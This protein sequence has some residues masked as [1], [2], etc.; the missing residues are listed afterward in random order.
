[1]L[2]LEITAIV[3]GCMGVCVK[4]VRRKLMSKAQ[5]HYQ[6]KTHGESKLNSLTDLISKALEDEQLSESEFKMVLC[7][8]EKYIDLKDKSHTNKSGLSEQEKKG[9]NGKGESG[10][11]QYHSI[12]KRHIIL[13]NK[14][15][16]VNDLPPKYKKT[17][18]LTHFGLTYFLY[19]FIRI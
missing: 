4:L 1:M 11:S 2:P 8:L 13:F 15:L 16:F 9:V 17:Q 7:D 14:F 18:N 19:L 5:K 3:C 6:I 10:G 12:S